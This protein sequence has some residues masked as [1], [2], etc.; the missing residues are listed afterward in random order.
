VPWMSHSNSWFAKNVVGNWRLVGTYT[1]ESGEMAT[2]QSIVD[3]NL[4]GDSA[5]D[6]TITNPAGNPLL[7]SDVTALKNTKG[8]I[9]AYVANNPNA[10]YIRARAGAFANTGR[11]TIQMPGINNFDLSL[12]KRFSIREGKSVEIRADA[13]NA[14]NHPQFTPG[15]INSVKLT[16][17]TSG[18]R[19]YLGPQ[20]S[21]FQAWNQIFPSNARTLQLAMKIVF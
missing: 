10:G 14:F 15:A 9:V 11:N 21:N 17:Y 20:N 1:A 5:G 4:N 12:G 16:S 18:D 19:T 8:D 13:S 7:G 2:A 6:R 3:A